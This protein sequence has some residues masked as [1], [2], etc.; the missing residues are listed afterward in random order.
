MDIKQQK[1]IEISA[2]RTELANEVNTEWTPIYLDDDKL[3]QFDTFEWENQNFGK[4][5]KANGYSQEEIDE[6]ANGFTKNKVINKEES[7]E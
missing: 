2:K 1:A 5:F 6:I 7:N 4:W 3:N